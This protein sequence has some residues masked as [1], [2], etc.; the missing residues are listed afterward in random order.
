[1][2]RQRIIFVG[3]F[4]AALLPS[5]G[6][7]RSSCPATLKPGAPFKIRHN[8]IEV[9]RTVLDHNRRVLGCGSLAENLAHELGH[10]LDLADGGRDRVCQSSVM[11][12]L[13]AWKLDSKRRRPRSVPLG[14]CQAVSHR[15]LTW[16]E[17]AARASLLD[18]QPERLKVLLSAEAPRK[19]ERNRGPRH[20]AGSEAM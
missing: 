3:L 10:L 7:T 14:A 11:G 1:M 15:W 6:Q 9:F 18:D 2:K 12:S 5:I 8:G 17:L 19:P 4:L 16:E 20:I 13:Y